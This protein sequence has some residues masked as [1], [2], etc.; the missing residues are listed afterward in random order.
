M[1][2]SGGIIMK[3][4]YACTMAVLYI[5]LCSGSAVPL[6][7][8]DAD[9]AAVLCALD[10]QAQPASRPVS[11]KRKKTSKDTYN[12]ILECGKKA[13]EDSK[14][15]DA[16]RFFKQ[17]NKN[18]VPIAIR[19]EA[20]VWLGDILRLNG[21]LHGAKA[22]YAQAK[23]VGASS[24]VKERADA[25]LRK[26]KEEKEQEARLSSRNFSAQVVPAAAAA[27]SAPVVGV[28]RERETTFN[29]D[30]LY[31]EDPTDDEQSGSKKPKR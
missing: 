24:E 21:D 11:N 29:T 10:Q 5:H 6:Q 16:I 2:K 13:F 18:N 28:K 15:E 20:R 27:Q 4:V 14:Y 9:V 19:Q 8:D 7:D 22:F 31:D 17:A 3:K 25:G 12:N 1:Y 23:R 30:L 26:I